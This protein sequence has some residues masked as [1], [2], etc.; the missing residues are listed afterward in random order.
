M[1]HRPDNRQ[2]NIVTFELESGV[3]GLPCEQ[4]MDVE[5]VE[6]LSRI[7]GEWSS[8]HDENAYRSLQVGAPSL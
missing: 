8:A 5:F 3:I 1:P 2:E 7:L 4:P 6:A